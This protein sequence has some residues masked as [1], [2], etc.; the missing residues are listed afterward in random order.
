MKMNRKGFTLIEL[1]AV[2]VILGVVMAIA[3]PS[4]TSTIEGSKK[5]TMAKTGQQFARGAANVLLGANELP[6]PGKG[7]IVFTSDIELSSGGVSPYTNE[8]FVKDKSYVVVTNVNGTYKYY[9][10]LADGDGNCLNAI[11]ETI[12]GGKAK[13]VRSYVTS[14]TACVSPSVTT[15]VPTK[16]AG[17][18]DTVTYEIFKK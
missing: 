4:M 7:V 9:V 8:A 12:I 14:G 10:T 16:I 5:D 2:I 13:V 18:D 6:S 1:L 3:I 15:T 11:D 17:I